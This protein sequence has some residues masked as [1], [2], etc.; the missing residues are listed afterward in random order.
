MPVFD[1]FFFL[2][3]G[4]DG[5]VV[6]CLGLLIVEDLLRAWRKWLTGV[7]DIL[8]AYRQR[9]RT[10]APDGASRGHAPAWTDH[11]SR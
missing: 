8:R 11:S 2:D 3:L 5:L 9:D 7:F 6:E 4:P 1:L 10:P